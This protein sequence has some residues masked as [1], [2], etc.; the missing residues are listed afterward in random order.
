MI[1]VL[2]LG[3][4]FAA[5]AYRQPGLPVADRVR[6]LLSRMTVPEKARQLDMYA[7]TAFI[8]KKLDNTHVAPDGR[9]QPAELEKLLGSLGAGSIHDLYPT[10]TVANEIQ[11]WVI[12]H[13]RLGIP[14]LFL[15]EGV[16]GY[17][18][19]RE[20]VY[21]CSINLAAT[22]DTA[23]AQT[24]AGQIASE[25]R[26][27]GVHMLLGPVLDVAREPRWGRIEEDFG[28]DAYLTGR[29]GASYVRGMQGDTLASDHTVISEPKHF[30]GHGSPEGG[31]NTSPVHAGE[32]E[33]R[34]VFLRSFEPAIRESHAR[35]VMAAYHEIDGVPCAGNPWLLTDVLRGEWG[36]GG[37]VLS[38]LGAI[39]ELFDRHHIAATPGDAVRLAVRS[40]LDM[41][42]YDF[43]HDV[44][45]NA[46]I[47][48]IRDHKISMAELDRAAGHVLSVK[49]EL[50]LFDH[51][52][53]DAGLNERVRRM[54][55]HLATSLASARESVCLLKNAGGL[56]PLRKGAGKI[57]VI[58][59]NAVNARLGDYT[60]DQEVHA[61][62]LVD[63]IRQ[64]DPSAISDSGEDIS[65]AVTVAQSADI[66]VLGLG[67]RGGISGEGSD[68]SDL[69]LPDHQEQLL[70]A[71][72][73][74][75]KPV[76]LVLTNGRPLALPWAAE[77]VPAIVEA[78]Y[79][80]EFGSRAIAEVLF[81][82]VNPSGHLPI[83]F[84][85]SVGSIP[86]FYNHDPSRGQVYV[87]GNGEPIW[88]FGWGLSYSTFAF[89]H[90]KATV[91]GHEV[92][93]TVDVKNDSN[94]EGDE[95][96]QLYLRPETSSVEMP[97]RNL[98]GF[99]RI[100]LKAGET[101]TVTFHLGRSELEIW[102]SKR[103]WEV[104]PG[105]VRV[106]VGDSSR[107]DLS[108]EFTLP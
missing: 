103:K 8:D 66:V 62:T 33:V 91:Q 4:L 85:R 61:D 47:E 64:V 97:V 19:F 83:S 27:N 25:A 11:K 108:T 58:G 52:F 12:D 18:G 22:W 68:R 76:V 77:H 107:A 81:G 6:D 102:G 90:A 46:L 44:F 56:L 86:D 98:K 93:V 54:P 37:F 2:A 63:A 3:F 28:E 34:S 14:A 45:Q 92:T 39:R 69:S 23:L 94:R 24:T 80:G 43:G 36:F 40:G 21:P 53:V 32:R 65:Q 60:A 50:G 57:A 15:E 82:Y 49:F 95:V 55:A 105:R 20:T 100:H 59:T 35:G 31:T 30:A 89:S 7:G 75:G 74:T 26:A 16:H 67:E 42:F 104:E 38:D 13:N 10:P 48:G 72:V 71:V 88:P 17:L 101:Q 99:S 79:P 5:P 73:K 87:D 106:W 78:F 29:L 84:P 9:V 1:G 70:E 96:A 41:Q 51:P